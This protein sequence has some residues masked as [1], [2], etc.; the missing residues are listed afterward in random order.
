MAASPV[1]EKKE[2]GT[3]CKPNKGGGLCARNDIDMRCKKR[4][5]DGNL[6]NLE[7]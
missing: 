3:V 5:W 1:Q 4:V 6:G 2:S 7:F